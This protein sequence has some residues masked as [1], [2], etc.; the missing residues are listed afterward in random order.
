MLDRRDQPTHGLEVGGLEQ[1]PQPHSCL[2]ISCWRW[3]LPLAKPN[4]KP[5]NLPMQS[6]LLGDSQVG[7]RRGDSVPRG[8]GLGWYPDSWLGCL[9]DEGSLGDGDRGEAGLREGESTTGIYFRWSG[10]PASQTAPQSVGGGG[11]EILGCNLDPKRPSFPCQ[12]L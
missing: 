4:W 2:P 7:M 8:R 1:T 10:L 3:Y 9:R 12:T 6:S 11:V 5:Q